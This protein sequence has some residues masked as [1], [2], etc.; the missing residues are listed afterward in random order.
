[1]DPGAP[2]GGRSLPGDFKD[3]G[4]SSCEEDTQ[5]G[6]TA[7]GNWMVTKD[8]KRKGKGK[9]K[10][11]DKRKGKVEETPGVYDISRTVALLLQEERNEADSDME[12]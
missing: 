1:V 2:C 11:N 7:T 8:V 6:E 4:D 5:G 10:S 12:G 9:G 3:N